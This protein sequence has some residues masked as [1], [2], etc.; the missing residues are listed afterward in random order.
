MSET[1]RR[2]VVRGNRPNSLSRV[3]RERESYL[4]SFELS[5]IGRTFNI[6]TSHEA[7]ALPVSPPLRRRM[8]GAGAVFSNPKTTIN[9]YGGH[10]T[11]QDAHSINTQTL[12][13]YFAVLNMFGRFS[14]RLMY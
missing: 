5:P 9:V 1:G 3:N 2:E 12:R 7:I 14:Q 13:T 6:E 4:R 10:G 11:H 8:P